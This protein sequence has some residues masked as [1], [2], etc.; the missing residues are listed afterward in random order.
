MA[1][2]KQKEQAREKAQKAAAARKG[3]KSQIQFREK[4]LQ[5]ICPICRTPNPNYKTMVLHMEA[6][7]P[8]KPI[9]PENA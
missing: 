8:G 2:G 6:K 9:P 1:R 7:H 3:G 5:S 4:G